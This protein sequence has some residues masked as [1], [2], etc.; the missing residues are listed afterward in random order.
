M[1]K[2]LR[3]T[4]CG[5]GRDTWILCH[6]F[7]SQG[8]ALRILGLRVAISKSQGPISRIL[9]VTVRIPCTR[10][11][12]SQS[13]GSQGLRVPGLRILGSRVSALSVP[14]P[15]TQVLILDYAV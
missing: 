1:Y 13:S 14:G 11:P 5:K 15:R 7:N 10:A 3:V 9:G 12:E 4:V 2:I 6:N 8:L